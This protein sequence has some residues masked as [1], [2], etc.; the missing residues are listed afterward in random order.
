MKPDIYKFEKSLKIKV[1]NK[2][3]LLNALTHKSANKN[4][5]N[6]KLEFL[7]DRVIGLVLAKKLLDLYPNENE[8]VLDKRF[9]TLVNKKTCCLIALSIDLQDFIIISDLKKKITIKDEKILSDACEALIG[10]VYIDKGFSFVENFVLHLWKKKIAQSNITILDPKTKLQEYSLK[11][12]KK[13][14]IYKVVSSDGPKHNPMFKISVSILGS[15]I[16]YGFGK[17]KQEA[18]QDGAK[19]LLKKIGNL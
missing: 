7:G 15:K 6:E 19:N 8:G 12:N 3:L 17:S 1:K 16:F 10:A 2:E 18:Q 13:L 11:I 4:I 14:P 5:N 9:A